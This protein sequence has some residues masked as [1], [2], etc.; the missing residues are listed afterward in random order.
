MRTLQTLL[1]GVLVAAAT[2]TVAAAEQANVT[3]ITITA[4][5]PHAGHTTDARV[6]PES[7]V[8]I[9]APMPTDMPEAEIDYHMP[10]IASL[11]ASGRAPS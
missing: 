1:F 4:K 11:A 9:V 7:R 10:P 6:P 5:R 2:S 3:T 8:E